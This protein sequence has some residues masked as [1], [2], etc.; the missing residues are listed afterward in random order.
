[1]EGMDGGDGWRGWMEDKKRE[2]ASSV[3]DLAADGAKA[4]DG[5]FQPSRGA[6]SRRPPNKVGPVMGSLQYLVRG[7]VS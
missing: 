7:V 2:A 4:Q 1:M 6:V 5:D 3:T